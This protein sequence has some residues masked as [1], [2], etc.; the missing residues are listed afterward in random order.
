MVE[1]KYN[2]KIR[3]AEAGGLEILGQLELQVFCLFSFWV[4][5][6]GLV[7]FGFSGQ[8]FSV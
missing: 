7:W 5:W 4:F 1:Q 3:K 6:F 8:D 2:L